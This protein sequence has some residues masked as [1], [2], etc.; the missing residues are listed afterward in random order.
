[1]IRLP[2]K[3]PVSANGRNLERLSVNP[4]LNN[5]IED[6]ANTTDAGMHTAGGVRIEC[7]Q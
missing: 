7:F 6:M 5:E 4:Y 3:K 2:N 1:M